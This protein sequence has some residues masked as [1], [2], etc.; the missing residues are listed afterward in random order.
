[1]PPGSPPAT[2]DADVAGLLLYEPSGLSL[3]PPY[4]RG[5][6]PVIFI[7]GLWS[8][9]RSWSPMDEAMQADP[10]LGDRYQ[11]QAFGYALEEFGDPI[12]S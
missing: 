12:V 5:R 3:V 11:F 4:R 10:A 7:H 8:S 2:T 6:I 9:P 1:M